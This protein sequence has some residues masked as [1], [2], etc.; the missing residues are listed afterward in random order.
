MNMKEKNKEPSGIRGMWLFVIFDLPVETKK[1]RKAYTRFRKRLL[2]EGFTMMQYS[3]Y[4]AYC[5][6]RERGRTYT[7]HIRKH[8]PAEGHV[9]FLMVTDKQF[10]DM[11]V[12]IGHKPKKPEEPPD[13]M[14]LF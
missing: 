13:Q 1:Q 7:N 11:E 5:N 6:C 10:G 14:M 4:A 12:Y 3:V 2:G 8:I 9:R